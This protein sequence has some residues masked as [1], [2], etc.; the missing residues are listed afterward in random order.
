[1]SIA[2]VNHTTTGN[3]A[4]PR[5]CAFTAA[6]AGNLL[7]ATVTTTT[8]PGSIPTVSAGTAFVAVAGATVLSGTTRRSTQ[9]RFIATGGENSVQFTAAGATL[10]ISV[11][12]YS[13]TT[14]WPA[15]PEDQVSTDTSS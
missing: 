5:T 1:M 15:T 13:S 12:E 2:L 9:Y 7:V 6:T 10:E 8:D 11:M 3:G 4:S 14:G